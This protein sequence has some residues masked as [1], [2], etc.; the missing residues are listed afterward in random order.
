VKR[1]TLENMAKLEEAGQV[2][3]VN[4]YQDMLN[5]LAKDMLN[6]HRRKTQRKREF[7]TLSTTLTN[8]KEKHAYLE[9]QKA[10]YH[11]YINSCMNQLNKK[12]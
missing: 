7:H 10:S 6:K 3:K 9:E 8:L 5:A 11:D 4:G 12:T 2:T 1:K